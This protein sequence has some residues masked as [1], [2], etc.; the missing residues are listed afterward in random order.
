[1]SLLVSLTLY[2]FGAVCLRRKKT[3]FNRRCFGL[4]RSGKKKSGFLPNCSG[5]STDCGKSKISI[6]FQANSFL[7]LVWMGKKGG[8]LCLQLKFGTGDSFLPRFILR[9]I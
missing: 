2:C 7:R 1:M 6:F 8:D 9:R 5:I 3:S 4:E